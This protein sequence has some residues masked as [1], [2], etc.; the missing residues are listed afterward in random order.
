MTRPSSVTGAPEAFTAGAD[1]INPKSPLFSPRPLRELSPQQ[2]KLAV[3][4]RGTS[5]RSKE[6]RSAKVSMFARLECTSRV[7]STSDV[8]LLLESYFT[9]P[10]I[11]PVTALYAVNPSKL[12]EGLPGTVAPV[13]SPETA[14]IGMAL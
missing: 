14:W 6:T 8:W 11:T 7:R 13:A 4:E 3:D 9:F 2:G 5:T 12:R 10:M 1:G